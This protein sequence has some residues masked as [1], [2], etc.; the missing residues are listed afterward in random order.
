M[1]EETKKWLYYAIP[2]VVVV[3]IGAALYYGRSQ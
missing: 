1:E 3:G 2:V